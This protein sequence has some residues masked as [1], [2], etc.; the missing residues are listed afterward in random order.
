MMYLCLLLAQVSYLH[1][2]PS[3]VMCFVMHIAP[4]DV[5]VLLASVQVS[6][7]HSASYSSHA[8]LQ[9]SRWLNILCVNSHQGK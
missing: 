8:L 3:D 5:H 7:L 1:V 9:F 4:V 2:A 6:Y